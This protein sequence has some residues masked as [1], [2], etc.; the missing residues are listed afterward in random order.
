M[1]NGYPIN[2]VVREWVIGASAMMTMW[3]LPIF[4]LYLLKRMRRPNWYAEKWVRTLIA[5]AV[6]VSGF[7][8]RS[9]WVW[10]VL[11]SETHAGALP[12]AGH[13][14]PID[15]LGGILTTIG[16]ACVIREISPKGWE[17]R[18]TAAAVLSTAVVLIAVHVI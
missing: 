10:A 14:W 7:M 8:V 15:L 4:C 11:W 13:L 9:D 17:T 5:F 6:M 2:L 18:L 1:T 12:D 16:A 3:I